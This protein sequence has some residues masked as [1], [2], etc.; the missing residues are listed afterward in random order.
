[1]SDETT[2]SKFKEEWEAQRLLKRTK[3]KARKELQK[4][5]FSHTE[6]TGL[7]K[8]AMNRIASNKPEKRAA[9]RGG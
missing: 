6:A 4:K 9:N 3:K 8:Q 1:M 2:T 5:G 7:V